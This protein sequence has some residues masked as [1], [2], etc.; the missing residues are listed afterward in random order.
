LDVQS[1][2][3]HKLTTRVKLQEQPFQVLV[4]LLERP[5]ELITREDL[6][7]KL[8]PGNTFVDFDHGLNIAINKLREALGDSADEPRYVQTVPRRGY[9]F[10][11]ELQ[12]DEPPRSAGPPMGTS[13]APGPSAAAAT[14][15]APPAGKDSSARA[16]ARRIIYAGVA[17]ALVLLGA[18][19]LV[20]SRNNSPSSSGSKSRRIESIAV[21]PLRNLSGDFEQEYF[22]D[23]MTEA[24]ITSLAQIS[25][26]RVISRTSSMRYKRLST[27]LPEIAR[28]LQVEAVVEGSVLRSGSRVRISAELVEPGSGKDLWARSYERELRDVLALQSEVARAIADEIQVQVTPEERLRLTASRSVDPTAQENYIKGRFYWNKR[29]EEGLRKGI[30]YF[31]QAID[32]EPNFPEAY[33]GLADCWISLAWYG[34]APSLDAY[35]RAKAAAIRAL[36]LN[37]SMAE[38]Q[39]SLAFVSGNY[40]FDWKAAEAGYQR[41]ISLNPNYANAHHWYADLLSAMGRH[42]QAIAESKR[43]R[44]LDP[45]SPIINTWLGWRYYFARQY[46]QAIVEY[47]RALDLDPNFPPAHLVFGQ[48]YEQKGMLTEAAAEFERAVSLSGNGA[49]YVASL[50]H[51]Y[52][53]AGRQSEAL[54]LIRGLEGRAAAGQVSSY[55]MAIA[56]LG[57]DR[58]DEAFAW[59]ERAA[60]EHAGRL[61]FVNVDPRFDRV[62][63]DPRFGEL[64]RRLKFSS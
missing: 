48:A 42:E 54:Q 57:V 59:L 39:T 16:S 19:L 6:R 13:A 20:T 11:G 50:A 58:K 29:T 37:G 34:Y 12:P 15:P 35:L 38:A 3:L 52:G 36:E 24:L 7:Q 21:L 43:A 30:G 25:A 18:L 60:L 61:A 53:L 1:G 17:V 14:V 9:R 41:A 8:W 23:G 33:D 10:T 63:S 22:A 32:T 44:A 46:D 26:L 31:Q 55:D 56:F 4:A 2:S 62:R 47:R 28:E 64:V 5:G 49:I 27:P 45:L 40:D 51:A